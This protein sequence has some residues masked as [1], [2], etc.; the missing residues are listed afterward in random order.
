LQ[1]F[2]DNVAVLAIE[3]ILLKDLHEVFREGSVNGIE[4]HLLNFIAAEPDEDQQTRAHIKAKL[5]K[6]EEAKQVCDEYQH[7][8]NRGKVRVVETL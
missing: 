2:T 8:A 4:K 7:M 3:M 5:S 6:L 1:T